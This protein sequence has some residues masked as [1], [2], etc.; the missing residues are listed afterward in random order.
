L[1]TPNA[2]SIPY[3]VARRN[4]RLGNPGGRRF[5]FKT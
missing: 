4:A 1:S 3:R 2:A 5:F